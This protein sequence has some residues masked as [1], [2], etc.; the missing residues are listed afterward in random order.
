MATSSPPNL[1][2]DRRQ[3]PRVALR[4]EVSFE[5]EH[6]FYTGFTED[7]SEGGLFVATY[8]LRPVGTEIELS[9]TLPDGPTIETVG[10]VRWIRDPLDLTDGSPPGMGIQFREL[11]P[12][13]REA[14]ESFLGA[15]SPLFYDD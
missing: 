4:S 15:R 5:S 14:I 1:A 10:V 13:E 11:P 6:N 12:E 7:I 3:H 8:Q 2:Q 9:F